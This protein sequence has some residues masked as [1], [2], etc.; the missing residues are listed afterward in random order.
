MTLLYIL[1]S[2]GSVQTE[3]GY[4]LCKNGQTIGWGYKLCFFLNPETRESGLFPCYEQ[5][6][7]YVRNSYNQNLKIDIFKPLAVNSLLLQK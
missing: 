5:Q 7:N 3:E 6:I 1:V 2:F 4:R